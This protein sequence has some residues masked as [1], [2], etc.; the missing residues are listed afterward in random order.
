MSNQRISA[1]PLANRTVFVANTGA[2]GYFYILRLDGK[3][4]NATDESFEGYNASN[5]TDYAID[6]EVEGAFHKLVIPK[7]FP[8]AEGRLLLP[9]VSGT[10]A[11]SASAGT[12]PTEIAEV[13]Y[14]SRGIVLANPYD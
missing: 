4:W 11:A 6:T 14:G 3:Y 7:T 1:P 9:F 13:D 12:A 2:T 8:S 5:I 10:A